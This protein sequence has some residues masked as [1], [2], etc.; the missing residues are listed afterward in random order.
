MEIDN[1]VDKTDSLDTAILNAIVEHTASDYPDGA[2][3]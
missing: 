2:Y 3:H 1:M